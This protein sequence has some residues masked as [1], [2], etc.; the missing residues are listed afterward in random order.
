MRVLILTHT[1]RSPDLTAMFSRLGELCPTDVHVLDKTKT[2]HL[3][4]FLRGLDLSAY[5]RILVDL[6]F[7]YLHTQA[8]VLAHLPGVLLYEEDACQ[9]YLA[10]SKWYGAFSRFYRQLPAARIVVTGASVARRLREEGFAATFLA[11]GYDARLLYDEGRARGYRA[12][13]HWAHG[14]Q[15]LSGP[16][17]AAGQ[18]AGL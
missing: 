7:K 17:G 6:P 13:L 8:A 2:R 1:P 16:Q 14:Q 12:G 18:S 9:N 3:K 15:R 4:A 11:K 5:T 10:G